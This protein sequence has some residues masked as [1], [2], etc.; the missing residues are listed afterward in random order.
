VAC[1]LALH[2]E[3][4]ARS[5]AVEITIV[6]GKE[7]LEGRHFN[8]CAGVLSPPLPTLLPERLGVAFPHHLVRTEIREYVVHSR[9]ETICLKDEPP[10]ALAL[11]RVQ[12]DA[13]MLEAAR[14]RG[15]R[16]VQARAT[17][18]EVR[19]DGVVVYTDN[20]P[21]A[22]DVV[23]GAFGLDEGSAA[24]FERI[25]GYRRPPA[26][27]AIVTKYHPGEAAVRGYG[28]RIHA[29]LPSDPAIEFGA[30]TPKGNH[31]TLN[32]AGVRV[33]AANMRA[34]IMDRQVMAVLPNLDRA[35]D[36][37]GMRFF[38]GR[39]PLGLA[40]GYYGDRY[41]MVGDA[42]GLVRPFKGKGVTSAVLSGIHAAET[43]ARHG[44][45]AQAFE[46]QYRPACAEI[47]GD[48]VY[49]RW[50]RRTVIALA[51]TG[52]LDAVLRAARG[53]PR[54]QTALL[55]AVSAR[56]P[57]RSVWSNGLAPASLLAILRHLPPPQ[58]REAAAAAEH[59]VR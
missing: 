20:Q 16:V 22:G 47:A 48:Q 36:P 1:A 53:E 6:E 42:A 44:V 4:A 34:F 39:F 58:Q 45:S 52:L 43:L 31:L 14:R 18:V 29:F 32:I 15:I 30:V 21:L 2:R 17:D 25:T 59:P 19:S 41:V 27:S 49:G 40:R 23:V 10:Y 46:S 54:L 24:I 33:T 9:R 13:Y 38:K 56:A 55:D 11:R 5:P 12:F 3:L 37:E 57:Y 35:E 50:M 51:Q 28:P 8:Q 7:F 26:M